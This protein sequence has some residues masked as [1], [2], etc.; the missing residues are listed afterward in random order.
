LPRRSPRRPSR[1]GRRLRFAL[2]ELE[3]RCLLS[4]GPWPPGFQPLPESGTNE[5]LDRAQDLQLLNAGGQVGAT[6][7][8]G[9]SPAGAADVDFYQFTL[10]GAAR[11]HL[12]TLDVPQGRHLSAVLSLYNADPLAPQ[13]HR[14]L[15][16]NDG[17]GTQGYAALDAVLAAGTYFVAVS[18]SGNSY[19]NPFLVGSGYNG[20]TGDYA[21]RVAALD[22]GIQPGDGPAVLSADPGP[23]AL[24]S[25][26]PL[27]LRLELSDSIDQ[28]TLQPD[29][30]VVLNYSATGDFTNPANFTQLT[31]VSVLYDDVPGGLKEVQVTPA[32]PLG[33]GFYQLVLEGD[34]NQHPGNAIL[35][36]NDV[37]PLG[38]NA[39]NQSGQDYAFTFHVTGSE[40]IAAAV[41]QADDTAATAHQLPTLVGAGIVQV[42]GAIGDDPSDPIPFNPNDV[43][44]YHFHI[45]GA[46]NYALAAEV[47]AGRIGSPLDPA[48]SLFH[49]RADGSLEFVA[50]NRNTNNAAVGT[51]GSVPLQTDA[52]LFVSLTAGDYYLAVSSGR[53][54]PDATHPPGF[55]NT[56]FDPNFSHSGHGNVGNSTGAYVLNVE[57]AAA[58]APTDVIATSPAEGEVLTAPPTILAVRFPGPVDLQQLAFASSVQAGSSRVAPVFILDSAGNTFYPRF[59]TFDA[60]TD[61]AVFSMVDALPNG[62]Y[63]LHLSGALGLTDLAGN[64]IVG[65][66]PS[67]DYVVHFSVAGPKRGTPGNPTAWLST[68]PNDSRSNPQVMGVLF[69]AELVHGV[70]VTRQPGSGADTADYYQFT[71]LRTQ[72]Y[73]FSLP[74]VTGTPPTLTLWNGNTPIFLAPQLNGTFSARL[75]PGTYVLGVSWTPPGSGTE[76][77]Q[78]L[79]DSQGSIETATPLTTGP[80]P[81]LALR[82]VRTPPLPTNV[83]PLPVGLP[84]AP[85]GG[86]APAP[87]GGGAPAPPVDKG[88]TALAPA[89]L[90]DS[91]P[92][93]VSLTAQAASPGPAAVPGPGSAPAAVPT[94][95]FV[96]LSEGPL[97]GVGGVSTTA[98]SAG[99][100]QAARSEPLVLQGL[101][102]I[103]L[104]PQVLLG[105]DNVLPPDQ[106]PPLEGAGAAPQTGT[107]RSP[108]TVDLGWIVGRPLA[109]AQA[110]VRGGVEVVG[111]FRGWTIAPPGTITPAPTEPIPVVE[112]TPVGVEAV[113]GIA[114]SLAAVPEPLSGRL[115]RWG[116]AAVVGLLVGF[117][118]G[119]R[120]WTTQRQRRFLRDEEAG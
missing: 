91:A 93:P 33:P 107:V 64:P 109:V 3:P 86:G 2:E 95:L 119:K 8:I 44:L 68:E 35:D 1:T 43:D 15:A 18:S 82:L 38:F 12:E 116:G 84:P 105:G 51:D 37:N 88:P 104:A 120:W 9:A 70:T 46:G 54:V 73:F 56:I 71:L 13:G 110:V 41:P 65:N 25:A 34:E 111:V 17:A 55:N 52:A 103:L 72:D 39:A 40:G 98:S 85:T 28:F 80:T 117:L 100:S 53:N 74:Q 32:A 21:M 45:D 60:P 36:V 4:G 76:S 81:A 101:A 61:V 89:A 14:L 112:S 75:P 78:L 115:L 7:T 114:G 19:F 10:G 106:A 108:T 77:Y 63:T 49:Q 42:A 5:T 90:S 31:G 30:N 92:L 20:S 59:Q 11:V 83:Q 79:M 47:F 66:D 97:G 26:S 87:T 67:G 113:P 57:V 48:L 6:G 96:V 102:A 27:V 23:G 22:A 118:S 62:N 16:Q 58:P 29:V 69:P 50:S 94:E 24:V 99:A